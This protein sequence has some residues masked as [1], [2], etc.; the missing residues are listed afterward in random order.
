MDTNIICIIVG[1]AFGLIVAF[2]GSRLTKAALKVKD[3]TSIMIANMAKFA[4]DAGA[5]VATFF[6]C[7]AASLPV[8]STLVAV[9]VSLSAGGI[10]MSVLVAKKASK[11]DADT[12]DSLYK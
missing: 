1:I 12:K 11:N 4:M 9:A 2:I 7:R 6:V 8:V 10:L 3:A 5:L